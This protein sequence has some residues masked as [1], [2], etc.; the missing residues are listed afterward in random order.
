MQADKNFVH[1]D[2][3]LLVYEILSHARHVRKQVGFKLQLWVMLSKAEKKK[4]V[5]WKQKANALSSREKH[6]ANVL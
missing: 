4:K 6:L 5:F 3:H 2:R 1:V